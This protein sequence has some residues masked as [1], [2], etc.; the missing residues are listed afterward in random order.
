MDFPFAHCGFI[1]WGVDI[2][3]FFGL[4]HHF[5]VAEGNELSVAFDAVFIQICA[6]IAVI[7]VADMLPTACY[8]RPTCAGTGSQ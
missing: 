2:A 1:A 5:A 7:G 4:N 3:F 6:D 8:M